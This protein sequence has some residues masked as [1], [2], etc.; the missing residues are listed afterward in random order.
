M[1]AYPQ[2]STYFGQTNTLEEGFRL[3]IDLDGDVEKIL[4]S[5]NPNVIKEGAVKELIKSI[6]KDNVKNYVEDLRHM[7]MVATPLVSPMYKAKNGRIVKEKP[8]YFTLKA[9]IAS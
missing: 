5:L 1:V 3:V 8:Y 6:N 4:L 2:Q 9:I 7:A